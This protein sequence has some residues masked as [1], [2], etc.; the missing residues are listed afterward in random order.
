MWL[1]IVGVIFIFVAVV[2]LGGFGSN[3]NVFDLL[4]SDNLHSSDRD[5]CDTR[6]ENFCENNPGEDWTE[7]YPECTE[8]EESIWDGE[9]C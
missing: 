3:F 7:R 1:V 6:V 2:V 9:T 4:V 5:I 8:F